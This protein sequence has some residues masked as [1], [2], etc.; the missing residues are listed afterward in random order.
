MVGAVARISPH[1]FLVRGYFESLHRI[2]LSLAV[3]RN[4]GITVGKSLHTTS[5]FDQTIDIVVSNLPHDIPR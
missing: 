5:V 2:R 1:D 4:H 3:S